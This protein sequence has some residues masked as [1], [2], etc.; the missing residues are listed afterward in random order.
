VQTRRRRYAHP[1]LG[2]VSPLDE[3]M[4]VAGKAV[5]LGVTQLACRLALDAASFSRAG[6]CLLAAA[7]LRLGDESL[8]KLVESEGKL[9]I[10]AQEA[11]QLEFDWHASDCLVLD[12]DGEPTTRLYMGCDGVM[13]PLVT[14]HEKRQRRAKALRRRRQLRASGKQCAPLEAMRGGSKERFKEMKLVSFYDQR[15]ERRLVRATRKNHRHA[16]RL[17]RQGL[18]GLRARG[19]KER[20]ALIDGAP[21]IERQARQRQPQFTAVTLDFWHLAEHVHA[22]RREVFGESAAEGTTWAQD[23]LSTLR[24]RGYDA[25]WQALLALRSKQRRRRARAAID[26]LMHYVAPRRAMLDYLRHQQQGWDI[27]SGPT[28]SMCKTLTRRVKGGKRWDADN[29]E[30]MMALEALLQSNQWPTWW[31]HRLKSAA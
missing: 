1:K 29:A 9:V 3:A 13:V 24:E 6:E 27:G 21:W 5:S 7:G 17:M 23:L 18:V 22:A 14:A 19:A 4:D 26:A 20:L 30:A 31:Q 10:A 25:F 12:A 8:R 15:R 16:G 11:E 2:S 28:E